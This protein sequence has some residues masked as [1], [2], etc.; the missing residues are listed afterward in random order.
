M[1]RLV[2]LLIL[3][4]VSAQVDE[5]WAAVPVLPSA[6]QADDEEYPPSPQRPREEECSPHRKRVFAGLK[7]RTADLPLVRRGVPSAWDLTTP[8]APPPLYVFMS[9]QI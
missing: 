2:Y 6:P 7:P 3:L 8:F 1:N 5:Y 9:L 4:L